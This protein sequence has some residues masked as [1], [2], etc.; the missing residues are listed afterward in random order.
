MYISHLTL[1]PGTY[2]VA[3]PSRCYRNTPFRLACSSL[4]PPHILLSNYFQERDIWRFMKKTFVCSSIWCCRLM[5][6][7]ALERTAQGFGAGYSPP[8]LS[9]LLWIAPIMFWSVSGL[10]QTC[11]SA[12]GPI[13]L[14]CQSQQDRTAVPG[15]LSTCDEPKS[16][17][18]KFLSMI[19]ICQFQPK[20][21]SYYF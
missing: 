16:S 21:T 7:G 4:P 18:V 17:T 10:L 5:R 12:T 6:D 13:Q 20:T 15:T 9:I 14:F 8:P 19:R 2:T 1:Q 3:S 11:L